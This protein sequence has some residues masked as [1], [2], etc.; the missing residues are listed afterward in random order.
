MELVRKIKIGAD[1]G[2]P[3]FFDTAYLNRLRVLDPS[4]TRADFTRVSGRVWVFLITRYLPDS[5]TEIVEIP[6]T[7]PT[8]FLT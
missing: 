7:Y 1:R 3:W 8:C 5:F 2:A 6:D 4:F